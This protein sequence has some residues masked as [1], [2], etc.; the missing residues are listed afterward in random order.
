MGFLR[1]RYVVVAF[2]SLI[3]TSAFLHLWRIST[4]PRPVF[5]EAYFSTFPA[6]NVLRETYFD[7][8]PP[9]GKLIFSLPLYFYDSDSLKEADYIK[10]SRN[11]TNGGLDTDYKPKDFKNF[12]YVDLR[13]ISVLFGLVF[14]SAFFL[15]VRE[16]AG[17]YAALLALFFA[18]F[19]NALLLH[20]R[21][22]LMDGIYM[23]F[24]LLGLYFFFRKKTAPVTAGLFWGLALSVKLTALA[25]IGPVLIMWM[26]VNNQRGDAEIKKRVLKFI[27]TGILILTGVW[28][29]VSILLFPAG[30]RITLFNNLFNLGL[31]PSFWTPIL[32]FLREVFYSLNGYTNGG[33]HPMMS[34]WYFWPVMLGAMRYGDSG[35]NIALIGNY[36]IWYLSALGVIAAIIKFVRDGIKRIGISQEFKPALILLGGYI[37]ALVPFFTIIRRATFLYHYFP[38]LVFALALASFLIIKFIENKPKNI[39]IAI[40]SSVVILTIIGFIIS[41]PYT[42]GL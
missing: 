3:A 36:F 1:K 4:P 2:I 28:F 17:N 39:K 29:F 31:T 22:I 20:T 16:V 11:P 42:Y 21:L 14:L 30:E 7:L 41:A 8:H 34:P 5:D 27:L 38:A 15:F 19:E 35:L 26:I 40:L 18:I 25:F 37:F 32:V 12:P 6:Q 13:L 33:G 10:L 24:G 9:L 23:A